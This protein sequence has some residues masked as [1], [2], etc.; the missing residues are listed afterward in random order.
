MDFMVDR[1]MNVT[2]SFIVLSPCQFLFNLKK[3]FCCCLLHSL[4]HKLRHFFQMEAKSNALRW[5]KMHPMVFVVI[6]S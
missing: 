3:Y 1:L 2:D 6:R 4:F 5:R